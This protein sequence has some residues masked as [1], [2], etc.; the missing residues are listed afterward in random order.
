M[1]TDSKKPRCRFVCITPDGKAFDTGLML[2]A[3]KKK[4]GPVMI[5]M[6]ND[7]GNYLVPIRPITDGYFFTGVV[8]NP[9]FQ[10]GA[11]EEK[12]EL[13]EILDTIPEFL[14]ELPVF[15]RFCSSEFELK[16]CDVPYSEL[17]GDWVSYETVKE[18]MPVVLRGILEYQLSI[19]NLPTSR[20][21]RKEK[22]S[23]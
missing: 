7:N 18:S 14:Y 19:N 11:A 20:R 8:K 3:Y 5:N 17:S 10:V 12:N 4:K 15:Y 16:A 21:P 13:S 1:M 23:C 22:T 2:S 9:Y 6:I